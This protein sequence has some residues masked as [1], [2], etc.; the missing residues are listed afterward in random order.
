MLRLQGPLVLFPEI[1]GKRIPTLTAGSA[2]GLVWRE[3]PVSRIFFY[4]SLG[5]PCK[6]KYPDKTNLTSLSKQN[7]PLSQSPRLRNPHSKDLQRGP[8]RQR[9]SISRANGLFIY[10]FIHS[11]LSECTVMFF[12]ETREKT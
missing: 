2:K 4:T 10:S 11:Y 6:K 8:Y 5:V 7:S 12:H 3:M 9:C 1:S